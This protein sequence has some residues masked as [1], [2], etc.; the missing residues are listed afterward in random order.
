MKKIALSQQLRH[1]DRHQTEMSCLDVRWVDW[2][3]SLGFLPMILPVL[4]A[5][6]SV[7]P[8]MLLDGMDGLIL[9]GGNDLSVTQGPTASQKRDRFEQQLLTA[10]LARDL[11]VLG[12]CRG[13]QLIN[14]SL[15]GGLTSVY[16]HVGDNHRIHLTGE[17]SLTVNS[18][19]QWGIDQANLAPVLQVWATDDNG[20][21]EGLSHPQARLKGMMWHPERPHP[22]QAF[23]DQLVRGFFQ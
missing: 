20:F 19:H 17:R 6:Q 14:V 1:D 10:A 12:V 4:N 21:I 22:D 16:G 13:M 3:Q 23:S 18:Y 5:H 15:G 2:L 8:G 11:P 7:E 9:T